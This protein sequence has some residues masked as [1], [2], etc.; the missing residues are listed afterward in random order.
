MTLNPNITRSEIER[1]IIISLVRL[2]DFFSNKPSDKIVEKS[3]SDAVEGLVESYFLERRD[4]IPIQK[5]NHFMSYEDIEKLINDSILDYIAEE[6]S[7]FIMSNW[8]SKY[9]L[10]HDRDDYDDDIF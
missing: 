5:A 8:Q 1:S 10:C 9:I 4:R 7:Y 6:Y 2:R 3:E